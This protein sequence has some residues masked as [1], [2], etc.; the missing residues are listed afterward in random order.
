MTRLRDFISSKRIVRVEDTNHRH[1]LET[2]VTTALDGR[3][4][5]I[6]DTAVKEILAD[7]SAKELNLGNGFAVSHT[8]LDA[9]DQ[10]RVSIGL[11][12][13]PVKHYAGDPVHTVFCIL[14]PNAQYRPYLTFLARLTR[15]ISTDGAARVFLSADVDRIS[16]II[17]EFDE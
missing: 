10:I 9:L 11:L 13:Q 15:L 1:I 4:N 6:R 14:I 5:P 8:R 2:L 7:R 17:A 16:E 3:E 12:P